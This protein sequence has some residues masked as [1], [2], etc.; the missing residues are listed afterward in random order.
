MMRPFPTS[1]V[2]KSIGAAVF[3]LALA[4]GAPVS[5]QVQRSL[6]ALD[7]PSVWELE[8][9]AHATQLSVQRFVD[10]ACG[11]RGG[12]PSLPIPDWT[13]YA[14]CPQEPDTGYYE[15]YFQYDD[16]LA[17][18]AR[19]LRLPMRAAMFQYTSAYAIPVIVTGLF[20]S[21]GFYVGF[22]MV[23]DARVDLTLREQ[24]STLAGF[25]MARYDDEAWTCEDLPPL[26]GERPYQGLFVKRRCTQRIA[27]DDL[28]L[29]LETRHMRKPGQFAINPANRLPTEGQFESTTYFEVVLRH[30]VPNPEE[31]L[32]VLGTPGPTERDALIARARDCPGCD[33]AGANLKRA[34][35]RGANL[36]G[37]NLAEANLHRAVLA[38]A[39]LAGA[40]LADA[41]LNRADV[42]QANLEGANLDSALL[43][44]TRLDGANLQRARLQ[45]AYAGRVQLIRADLRGANV[46]DVDM[47]DG[48][49][50]DVDFRGAN[51]NLSYLENAQ[52]ARANFAGANVIQTSLRYASM[53]QVDLSNA[54]V[55][56]SDLFRVNLRAADLRGADFTRARLSNANLAETRTDGAVFFEALLP[57]GFA[58]GE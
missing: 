57:A 52:L 41:N 26:E 19:A 49:L 38:G 10:F 11:T 54:D 4:I 23:T 35:L 2:P 42:K 44:E 31:R 43:F 24:G 17:Y 28:D 22:R 48:R 37:A 32:A 39:N 29:V 18:V 30:G 50:N 16:E 8:I 7:E 34:D 14:T 58:P 51:V 9:G 56:G 3:G 53:V 36:Q 45:G 5:A 20:D 1:F 12:P 33:F 46:S 6:G 40:N 15:V 21:N 55:R 25:L 27:A 13:A 47:R